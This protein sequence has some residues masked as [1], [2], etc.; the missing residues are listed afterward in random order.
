M[1]KYIIE[2]DVP[3][4]GAS[5]P[6]ELRD[7][8]RKSNAALAEL[9]PGIQWQHSYVAGDKTFCVYLAESE[10]LIYAHAERSGFPADAITE[11]RTIF[12]PATA[13]G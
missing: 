9:A 8:A 13:E 10:D 4:I 1:R 12:D 7:G 11:I 2:R 5:T 3:G 6:E